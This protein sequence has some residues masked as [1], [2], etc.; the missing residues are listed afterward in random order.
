MNVSRR[1]TRIWIAAIALSAVF[2]LSVASYALP[3]S[4]GALYPCSKYV[5]L[6]DE[7]SVADGMYDW[8]AVNH[9]RPAPLASFVSCL[10][11]KFMTFPFCH[12][13]SPLA[14]LRC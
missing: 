5:S 14:V 11:S 1:F 8:R 9:D 3:I 13:F 10:F 12:S 6:T 4:P 7:E 2:S